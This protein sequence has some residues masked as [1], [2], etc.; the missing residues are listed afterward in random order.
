MLKIDCDICGE[1]L[2]QAGALLFSP[3]DMF[4]RVKQ[5]HLCQACFDKFL[6]FVKQSN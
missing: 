2:Q 1:E 6:Q 4:G 3:P 5:C